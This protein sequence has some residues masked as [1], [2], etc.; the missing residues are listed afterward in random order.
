M[1]KSGCYFDLCF[2][3]VT[4]TERDSKIEISAVPKP[5]D[6]TIASHLIFLILDD[7]RSLNRESFRISP[8]P[9]FE[10]RSVYFEAANAAKACSHRRKLVVKMK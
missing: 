4:Y 5:R 6:S 8:N 9:I 1:F 10:T 7:L 3:K 2:Y